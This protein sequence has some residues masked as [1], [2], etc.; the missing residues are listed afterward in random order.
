MLGY[1]AASLKFGMPSWALVEGVSTPPWN[2]GMSLGYPVD[3][4][5][6][7]LP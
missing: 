2:D 6:H 3:T 1:N 4:E 7:T 5:P